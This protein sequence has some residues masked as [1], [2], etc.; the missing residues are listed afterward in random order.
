MKD[1]RVVAHGNKQ[2]Q[3]RDSNRAASKVEAG[4]AEIYHQISGEPRKEGSSDGRQAR[5]HGVLRGGVT[6]V[7]NDRGEGN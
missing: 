7:G 1:T 2:Q 3:A 5:E 4:P 6:F